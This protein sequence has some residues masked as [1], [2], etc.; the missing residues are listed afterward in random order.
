MAQETGTETL[1]DNIIYLILLVLFL[2]PA[3]IFLM[4]Q[5]NGASVWSD[6]YAK[7]LTKIINLAEP[8]DQITINVNKATQI[9]Q[10]NGVQS[11]NDVFTFDN[12]N[13]QVC[14]KLSPRKS[15]CY[16]FFNDVD[17]IEPQIKLGTPENILV[18]EIKEVQKKDE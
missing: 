1:W 10:K 8:G 17:I 2:A 6:Y 3:I 16:H 18:F 13:N 15:A 9:S 14:V 7:E 5:M 11:L 12:P 4:G